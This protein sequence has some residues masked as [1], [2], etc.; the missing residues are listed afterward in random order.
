MSST[1]TIQDLVH[2]ADRDAQ[3]TALAAPS[4]AILSYEALRQQTTATI[5]A[6]RQAGIG[7][8]DRVA[9]VLPNG[10]EMAAALVAVTSGAVCSPL[11]PDYGAEE[12]RFYLNDLRAAALLLPAGVPGA[13]R[14]VAD[15]LGVRCLD[16]RWESDWPAGRFVLGG[17]GATGASPDYPP[18]A[19]DVALVLHTSGTTARPKQVPLTHANLVASARNISTT[20]LLTP[21]DRCLNVMPLFHIHGIAGALLSSLASGASVVCTP[22]F[23]SPVFLEWLDEFHPT[24]YT[25]VPAMH[26][27][28]LARAKGRR[29][30]IGCRLRFIRSSS[31]ALPPSVMEALEATFHAPVIEAYGM[32]EA[33]HQM[34]SNPLPPLA[35]KPGSVGLATGTEIATMDASGRLLPTGAAGEIVIRGANVTRGYETGTSSAAG[36]TTVG[37]GWFR[38]GDEGRL[39]ADGYLYLSGR[40]KEIINRGG[41]KIS[42]REVDEVLL[43]H[44][45][46]AEAVAF[47][48]PDLRL[49]EDVG[50]VVVLEPGAALTEVELRAFAA[51]RLANFKVP[52]TVLF[53][54]EI[55]R[56]PTGK[57]Q[58]TGLAK[59]L[60]ISETPATP[61]DA[62]PDFEAPRTATEETLSEIWKDV[63]DLPR[64]GIHERFLDLGGD[65]IL[66]AQIVSRVSNALECE[67]SLVQFFDHPTIAQCADALHGAS[68]SG[69]RA[70]TLPSTRTRTGSGD[71]PLSSAQ[72]RL[73]FLDQLDPGSAVYNRP[74]L[75][76]LTG[77]FDSTVAAQ[78]LAAIV[79]RHEALRTIFCAQDGVP[80]Q[81]ILPPGPVALIDC[82]SGDLWPEAR[83]P[84]DLENGPLLRA[85][86]AR[87]DAR[88]HLLLLATHHIVFDDWSE[89]ILLHEFGALYRQFSGGAAAVL[90]EL[91]LQVADLAILERERLAAASPDPALSYWR[92]RLAGATVAEIRPDFPRPRTQT[93]DGKRLERALPPDLSA[94]LRMLSRREGVT[95][96]TTMLAVFQALL[97]RYTGQLEITVGSPAQVRA[98]SEA[99]NLIGVFVNT[100][101]L[102]TSLEGDPTVG[103][104]LRRTRATILEAVAHQHLP[105]ERLVDALAP[106]RDFSRTPLFQTLFQLREIT[107]RTVELQDLRVTSEPTALGVAKFDL[108][109]DI[110]GSRQGLCLVCDYNTDLFASETIA[111]LLGHYETLLT[112]AAGDPSRRITELEIL[113]VEER[114]ALL[115][116]SNPMPVHALPN[117]RLHHFFEAQVQSTPEA[118]AAVFEN[119]SISYA[120]LNRR[121]DEL[122]H[123][124]RECGVGEDCPVGVSI[125]RSFE[126][127]TAVLAIL[128]AGGACVPLD[129]DYPR[130]R[131]DFMIAEARVHMVLTKGRLP[132]QRIQPVAF[133]GDPLAYVIF[134]SGST[135]M[136]KAVAMGHGP[137]CNLVDWQLRHPGFSPSRKTLQFASLSFDV[138]FQEMFATWGSGGTLVLIPDNLRRDLPQLWRLVERESIERLYLPFVALQGFAEIAEADDRYPAAL[139]EVIT[140]GE[141]LQ[142]TEQVRRFFD[143]LPNC[144]LDNQ[145]G[146][147]E[148]H[149]V[150]SYR[151]AG[152]V[153][154]WPALPPIGRAITHAKIL[155]LDVHRRLVPIGVPGELHIGGP[156]LARGYLGQPALTAERFVPDPY[157]AEPGARLYCT[158]DLARLLPA[159][160][161]EF[162]GRADQQVKI[163]GYRVELGEIETHLSRHSAVRAVAVVAKDA[164]LVAYLTL[165]AVPRPSHHEWVSFLGAFLP[166]PMIPS[167]FVVL[168]AMPLLPSGKVDRRALPEPTLTPRADGRIHGGPE[169]ALE[170]AIAAIWREVLHVDPVGIDDNFFDL[171]GHSLALAQVHSRLRSRLTR[172]VPIVD[173]FRHSTVR[174]LARHLDVRGGA[175]EGTVAVDDRA[176]KQ[177]AAFERQRRRRG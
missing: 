144:G 151:L 165:H 31:S 161:I 50:A 73:W 99:E 96:F 49:G 137:L 116:A 36:T 91:S 118:V 89:R 88:E 54:D 69:A 52:R 61:D 12:F 97:G 168:D 149:V 111:R 172:D 56:G 139:R 43:A 122:A 1:Q 126:M 176:R 70:R 115:T 106:Q 174:A 46:V 48:L 83:R 15:E 125:E 33:A 82:K 110:V 95:L 40:L 86:L 98:G 76:R 103:E 132:S 14:A 51:V 2:P 44:P 140:A 130:Q 21:T 63:L 136:P 94:A 47:A 11:N 146:P 133:S 53:R 148:A 35:R 177:R 147:A 67:L 134:T 78:A 58:R 157:A 28:I 112:A 39:D 60:G 121:A 7:N 119:A 32:T 120:E 114:R 71:L 170:H 102:R 23:Q 135:G 109:M 6:L 155:I 175:S 173:L 24:W 55:P 84:F 117:R 68:R 150:T 81:V 104:L 16:L 66:A 30:A 131:L 38:T 80:R 10:P 18:H 101:V 37:E 79:R 160:D 107:D 166:E 4:R 159:G 152:P 26:Q 29:D 65:S 105:F 145:Y 92:T 64:V 42:P 142:I 20:L 8:Q 143:R 13:A 22:G 85:A 87:V 162:L 123:H 19:D 163:R 169:T 59:A 138:A 34:A 93:F 77:A 128:K 45:L 75:L 158:G 129:P 57:L 124:L 108:S 153:A 141:Q 171:G 167:S 27:A 100:L 156:V 74:V 154:A 90:P 9:V 113:G 62:Q 127:I 17:G 5:A 25:A 164:R 72:L 41:E 3:A